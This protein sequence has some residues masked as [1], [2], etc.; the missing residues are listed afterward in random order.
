MDPVVRATAVMLRPLEWNDLDAVHALT[1]RMEVVRYM[2]LPLCSRADAE[3]FLR[4]ALTE[5]ADRAWRWIVRAICVPELAGLAGVSIVCGTEEG[6]IWHLVAAE[7]GSRNRDGS[8]PGTAGARVL[9]T[10]ASRRV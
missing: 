9:G 1:S 10:T 6:E 4:D 3:L 5:S 8:R 7:R 2:L